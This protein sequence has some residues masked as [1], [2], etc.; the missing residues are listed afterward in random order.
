MTDMALDIVHEKLEEKLRG[1]VSCSVR[2]WLL[3]IAQERDLAMS[4][5]SLRPAQTPLSPRNHHSR[6]LLAKQKPLSRR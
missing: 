2:S 4:Q 1:V 5:Q 6:F 3:L